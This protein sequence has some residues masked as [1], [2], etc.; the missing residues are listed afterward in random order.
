MMLIQSV[1][2]SGKVTVV[3]GVFEGKVENLFEI[4]AEFEFGTAAGRSAETA[5]NMEHKVAF[6]T[7]VQFGDMEKTERRIVAEVESVTV[8]KTVGHPRPLSQ[9]LERWC[10]EQG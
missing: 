9:H 3:E 2:A 5:N 8:R 1:F 7:L 6:G 4:T 10:F